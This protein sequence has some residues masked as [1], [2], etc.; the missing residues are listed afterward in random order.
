MPADDKDEEHLMRFAAFFVL[1][2]LLFGTVAGDW[3]KHGPTT[4]GYGQQL[5][6][7]GSVLF[8]LF[9]LGIWVALRY[10]R[11][12][13]FSRLQWGLLPPFALVV[14]VVLRLYAL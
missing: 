2:Y 3:A 7:G 8:A 9:V 4:A 1:A 5:L 6:L 14:G 13:G 10:G 11:F 12:L